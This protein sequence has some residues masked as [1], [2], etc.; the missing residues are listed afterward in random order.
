M[1]LIPQSQA[2]GAA[3]EDHEEDTGRQKFEESRVEVRNWRG[4]GIEQINEKG[5]LEECS[6]DQSHRPSS[7]VH[8]A[9]LAGSQGQA[10]I[11]NSVHDIQE[12]SKDESR[13][14]TQDGRNST[15]LSQFGDLGDSKEAELTVALYPDLANGSVQQ[16]RSPISHQNKA[17]HPAQLNNI[18]NS[19]RKV[20]GQVSSLSR[21][22]LH[23]TVSPILSIEANIGRT[24]ALKR[25]VQ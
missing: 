13:Y 3:A 4:V 7:Q 2:A 9:P 15:R 21:P 25:A 20:V 5:S 11:Q 6:K 22:A 23:T 19:S 8:P 18:Y 17:T 24:L 16:D 12:G 14:V 1:E 10:S